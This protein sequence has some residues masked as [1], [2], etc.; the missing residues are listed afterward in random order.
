[1]AAEQDSFGRYTHSMSA[2]AA[3]MEAVRRAALSLPE[4]DRQSLAMELLESIKG[5]GG[6]LE[7]PAWREELARRRAEVE[8]GEADLLDWDEARKEIFG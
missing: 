1:M 6:F 4:P 2:E 3:R 8:S 5:D 7:S